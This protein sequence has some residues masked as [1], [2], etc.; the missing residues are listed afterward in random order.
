MPITLHL[1]KT[2]LFMLLLCVSSAIIGA[3]VV[4][5]IQPMQS[6]TRLAL[7]VILCTGFLLALVFFT[8]EI[9]SRYKKT[10]SQSIYEA[11]QFIT[12]ILPY[13]AV[14]L[15]S[16]GCYKTILNPFKD[17]KIY[18]PEA[19]EGR[20]LHDTLDQEMADYC[21]KMV[22]KAISENSIQIV[23]YSYAPAEQVLYYEG[24]LVPFNDP[25]T[26]ETYVI[27]I[28]R[29]ISERKQSEQK[30]INDEQRIRS[31][32]SALPDRTVI[33]DADGLYHD[34]LKL[35]YE[36]ASIGSTRSPKGR[37]LHEI[38][39]KG[40]ADFCMEKVQ[41][42]IEKD[43]FQLFDYSFEES[44]KTYH[45]EGRAVPYNDI[46]TG[47][48]RVIWI[49][50]DIT[51]R[52]RQEQALIDSQKLLLTIVAVFPD[53]TLI[54]NREGQYLQI[55]KAHHESLNTPAQ[56]HQVQVGDSVRDIFP[57]NFADF[58]ISTI[59][60]T[61]ESSTIQIFEYNSPI[62]DEEY[63]FEGR[64]IPF[65]DPVSGEPHV[66]W[67][68]RDISL[69]KEAEAQ[70][71]ALTIEKEKLEF[72]RDFVNN[73]THDLKTPLTVIETSLYLSQR[74]KEVDERNKR[75]ELARKQVQILNAMIDD[76][77]SIARFD[78]IP[79]FELKETNL[80]DFLQTLIQDILPRAEHKLQELSFSFEPELLLIEANHGELGRAITNLIDNAIKYTPENGKISLEVYEE[81][82]EVLIKIQDSG[83]G[84]SANSLPHIFE[85]FYRSENGRFAASGTGLGL[86]ITQHIIELHE[87]RIHVESKINQGSTFYVRL[88]VYKPL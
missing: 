14:I 37:R 3:I 32:V 1:D 15:D 46:I 21:L 68:S 43:S 34:V 26:K 20:F 70:R 50:R 28:T 87:G 51:E 22:K 24:H 78:N 64:T 61:I 36:T 57:K 83:I 2:S 53:R 69:R 35:D 29:D 84:I 45:L 74:A 7:S 10:P 25:Q 13:R 18:Q 54:F 42:T 6:V 5:V 47:E 88:P 40:F 80:F 17:P 4:A 71:L 65:K 82:D 81:Q 27:W 66:L 11:L 76:M 86:A 30:L 67:V 44:G 19:V 16:E 56:I 23:E 52:K 79:Q 77:L 33:L 38:F 73:M 55:L 41:E 9:I 31:I 60:K 58:C 72:F 48:K 75:F 63:I 62:R 49:S 12:N 39:D 59:E 85:R 8:Q